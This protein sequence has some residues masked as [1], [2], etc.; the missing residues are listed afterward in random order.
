[1]AFQRLTAA[2]LI[3]EVDAAALISATRLVHNLT[4]ILRLCL[5]EAFDPETA[6]KGLKELLA[7]AGDAP[8]FATLEAQLRQTL[9]EVSGLFSKLIT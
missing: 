8:D 5:T 3:Q 9:K 4:Q 7:R 2:G 1:L 6:S